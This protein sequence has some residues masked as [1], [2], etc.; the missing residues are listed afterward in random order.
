MLKHCV[1]H[2]YCVDLQSTF[3]NMCIEIKKQENFQA[4]KDIL[5]QF[6][7]INTNVNNYMLYE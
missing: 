1:I 2:Y 5:S 6:F 7:Y 3:I 4:W